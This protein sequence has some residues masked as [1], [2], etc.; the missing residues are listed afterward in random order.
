MLGG[1]E[2]LGSYLAALGQRNSGAK[3]TTVLWMT[4][5][6]LRTVKPYYDRVDDLVGIFG[7]VEGLHNHPDG[8]FHPPPKPRCYAR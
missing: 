5:D 8:N 4:G 6:R 1:A 7:S 3:T 2:S